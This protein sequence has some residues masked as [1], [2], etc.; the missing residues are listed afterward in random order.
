LAGIARAELRLPAAIYEF[1]STLLLLS[2]GM[3]GGIELAKQP[4]GGLFLDML[5]VIALGGYC[6]RF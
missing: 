3:K 6:L 4:F 5:A 1:V 2:I